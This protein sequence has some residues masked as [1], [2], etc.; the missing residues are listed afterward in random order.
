M[1]RK[2]KPGDR[3]DGERIREVLN[4]PG[5]LIYKKRIERLIDIAVRTLIETEDPTKGANLRGQI[6]A[7]RTALLIPDIIVKESNPGGPN[8]LRK[9]TAETED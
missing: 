9:D 6:A 4:L 3:L 2:R 7:L 5:W 1:K 8:G